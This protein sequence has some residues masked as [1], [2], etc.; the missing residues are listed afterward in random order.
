MSITAKFKLRKNTFELDVEFQTPGDSIT[1][2][3]GPSGS[4]KTT[5]LRCI[6]GLEN[7]ATGSLTVNNSCWQSTD[8]NIFISTSRRSVGY[9]F[10]DSYLFPHLLVKK[11]LLFGYPSF[12]KTNSKSDSSPKIKFELDDV[13]T[14]LGISSLLERKSNSL[15][16][17]ERQ[18][19]AI[20]RTLLSQPDMILMDEPVSALDDN[21][22]EQV[23]EYIKTIQKNT[24]IPLLYVSHSRSEL[25][26]LTDNVLLMEDGKLI[27]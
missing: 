20:A 4:G 1:V 15:S 22:K 19:V 27:T 3:S 2:I 17:G 8:D 21:R 26:K 23:I 5:L 24:A 7:C 12:S 16:G 9:V 11:N 25:Q 6:A 10:Q 18:R 14:H 13:I